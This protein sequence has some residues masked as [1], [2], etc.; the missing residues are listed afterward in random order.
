MIL[1]R[2]ACDRAK[3]GDKVV[4]TGCLA[5]VPD[6]ASLMSPGEIPRSV[7]ID[8]NRALRSD[9]GMA[10]TAVSGLQKMGRRTVCDWLLPVNKKGFDFRTARGSGRFLAS[11]DANRDIVILVAELNVSPSIV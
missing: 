6:V 8:R 4:I 9:Y 7:A 1:G 2:S 10:D 3:P 5:A 11:V